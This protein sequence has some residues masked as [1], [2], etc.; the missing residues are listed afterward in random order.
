LATTQTGKIQ[1][2]TFGPYDIGDLFASDLVLFNFAMTAD[3]GGGGAATDIQIW[4]VSIEGVAFQDG[5]AL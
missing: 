1:S 4:S 5:E 3:G 2:E